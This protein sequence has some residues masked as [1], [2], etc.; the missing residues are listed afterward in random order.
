MTRAALDDLREQ[1]LTREHL[2]QAEVAEQGAFVAVS[3][4]PGDDVDAASSVLRQDEALSCLRRECEEL[5]AIE[6]ALARMNA[7]QYGICT[8]CNKD[9]AVR[10]LEALP[11]AERCLSCQEKRERRG[12]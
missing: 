2:L 9:I 11:M 6:G 7:G 3:A 12:R 4:E 5:Q 10:R 8:D 1:L